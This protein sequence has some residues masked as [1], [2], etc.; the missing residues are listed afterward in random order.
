MPEGLDVALAEREAEREAGKPHLRRALGQR[1]LVLLFVVAVLNLTSVPPV[2]AG[3]P[4]TVWLWVLALLFFFWPQGV[5]VIE[6]SDRYPHEGGVYLWTKEFFGSFH[7][8]MSGWCYWTN[9][10]FYIPTLVLCVVG[11]S[12]YMGGPAWY[13]LGDD[14]RYV[15]LLAVAVLWLMTA[16]HIL[17]LHVGKWINILGGIG[18]V[19]AALVLVGLAIAVSRSQGV[20]LRAS[21]F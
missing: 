18:A 3:G 6:L 20:P 15:P 14:K 7:G 12:V 16:I 2:A 13:A 10:M 1:D 4:L 11:I 17:G 19:V 9:N 8:F 5:A 21:D